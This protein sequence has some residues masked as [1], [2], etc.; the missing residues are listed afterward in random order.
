MRAASS[1]P[2]PELVSGSPVVDLVLCRGCRNQ[3]GM[4]GEACSPDPPRH[5]EQSEGSM[6]YWRIQGID[7]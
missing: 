5:P 7:R 3:F 4:T 6:P 2:H 1:P